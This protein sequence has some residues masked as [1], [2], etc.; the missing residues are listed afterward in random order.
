MPAGERDPLRVVIADDVQEHRLLL[1]V[2][3][4][5]S[6]L[7]IVASAADGQAAVE[8][9]RI[10]RP[11]V[12]LLDLNMPL[13][14]GLE[15]TTVIRREWPETKV[16]IL[17]SEPAAEREAD[18]R[19]VGAQLYLEK[20]IPI[21][22]LIEALEKVAGAGGIET[23]ERPRRKPRPAPAQS[24]EFVSFVVHELRTPVAVIE[25]FAA[26][27]IASLERFDQ[28][29]IIATADAIRR[30][31]KN[32]T[33]L[34]DSFRDVRAL[35]TGTLTLVL[36]DV[37]LA[38]L[39]AETTSDLRQVTAPHPLHCQS[40]ASVPTSLDVVRVRQVIVNLILNA[41]K[42]SP[43]ESPIEVAA[44][45]VKGQAALRVQDRGPGI[46]EDSIAELFDKYTRFQ[47]AVPGT[48]LGLYLSRGI[49]R[50]HGGDLVYKP[51]E[52]GGSTFLATL[53]PLSAHAATTSG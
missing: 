13:K 8:A 49:A 5:A 7:Q 35:E 20:G 31:T 50:A 37:D 12:A 17:S 24:D 9:V 47:K 33:A 38:D 45:S 48:G 52:G 34:V 16:V 18:A 1:E 44:G 25:G 42:F 14:D 22:E 21:P 11:D 51:R 28:E 4:S 3:L 27:L 43:A 10:H 19:S 36:D 53:G 30:S 46:P 15:A 2:A 29:T 26:T 39:V 23:L 6:G 40:E 32:L 41:A